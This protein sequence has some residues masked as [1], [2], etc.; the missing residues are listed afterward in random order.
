VIL[1]EPLPAKV[2]L[3]SAR[4]VFI[5]E[6]VHQIVRVFVH[7]FVRVFVCVEVAVARVLGLAT[8]ESILLANFCGEREESNL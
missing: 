2:H 6:N 1:V 4:N 8:P 3:N 5:C 7:G